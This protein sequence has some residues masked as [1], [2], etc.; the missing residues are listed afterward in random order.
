MTVPKTRN[1]ET[2][3]LVK[4]EDIIAPVCES[5]GRTRDYGEKR[6]SGW[7][8]S[9]VFLSVCV[10]MRTRVFLRWNGRTS[11]CK[12]RQGKRNSNGRDELELDLDDD[13][14]VWG[15]KRARGMCKCACARS[16]AFMHETRLLSLHN[17]MWSNHGA[18][19]FASMDVALLLRIRSGDE[20][21]KYR[22]RQFLTIFSA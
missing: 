8:D 3:A 15:G 19:T 7:S 4:P 13:G 20:D 22:Q 14:R 21:K 6:M 2:G 1:C 11:L 12:R 18:F 5:S 17:T 9:F 16:R 10:C